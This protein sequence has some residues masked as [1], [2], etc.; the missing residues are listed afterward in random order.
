MSHYID[1]FAYPIHRDR[2]NEYK[3]LV[4]AAAVIWKEHGALEYREFI[5]DDLNF[6]GTRSFADRVE[7]TED[8]AVLFGW[9]TFESREARDQVNNKVAAD[10]RMTKL[11]A[12]PDTGFDPQRMLYGGFQPFHSSEIVNTQA[13][14]AGDR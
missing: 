8:E 1:G 3:N 14:K 9:I 5:G 2:L 7:A 4:E 12:A 11:M 6:E 10:P 13:K